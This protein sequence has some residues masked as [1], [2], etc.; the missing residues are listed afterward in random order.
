MIGMYLIKIT[1][2]I[3]HKYKIRSSVIYLPLAIIY[4]LSVSLNDFPNAF[5]IK[6]LC[7]Y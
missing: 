2:N 5:E 4:Y 6:F 1:Q 7:K 3:W